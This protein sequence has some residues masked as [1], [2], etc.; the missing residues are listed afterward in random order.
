MSTSLIKSRDRVQEHGEVFTP[1]FI[2]ADMLALVES[3]VKNIESRFLEPACGDGNFLAAILEARLN[4]LDKKY[5]C[6]QPE[7]ERQAFFAVSSLYGIELLQ[8]NVE[9][10]RRRLFSVFRVHYEDRHPSF[11][12]GNKYKKNNQL[13]EAI[14]FVLYCNIVQG[15]ALDMCQTQGAGLPKCDKRGY[16]LP[17]IFSEW[18]TYQNNQII[19]KEWVYQNLV[20][21]DTPNNQT[22]FFRQPET[23]PVSG[24]VSQNNKNDLLTE[25]HQQ[26]DLFADLFA[27]TAF[28]QPEK[29]NPFSVAR[30]LP[31]R[32][33]SRLAMTVELGKVAQPTKVQQATPFTQTREFF[34]VNY[35]E[36]S[37]AIYQKP[38]RHQR[39][40]GKNA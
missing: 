35:W 10:C 24:R 17:I 8:D 21:K 25:N 3:K 30:G 34:P 20:N 9:R 7:W 32:D 39:Q 6:H 23:L 5:R 40:G 36:I 37:E 19:R 29:L 22:P 33:E 11:W 38:R 13:C 26:G 31:R 14:H 2:V 16:V 27:E 15:N 28:R 1:P 12:K 18:N 4:Q